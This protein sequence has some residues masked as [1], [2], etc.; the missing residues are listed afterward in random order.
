MPVAVFVIAGA[1]RHSASCP[2]LFFLSAK[3][4]IFSEKE[5][6]GGHKT[7]ARRRMCFRKIR[8]RYFAFF[9]VS[10]F[11]VD[12]FSHGFCSKTSVLRNS[13]IISGV[14]KACLLVCKS[15]SFIRQKVTFRIVKD[16]LLKS[17]RSAARVM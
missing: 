2:L 11:P 9:F 7:Y 4:Y 13:L 8:H 3:L 17:R 12:C 14:V 10:C 1:C 6:F 16:N 15:L 5:R